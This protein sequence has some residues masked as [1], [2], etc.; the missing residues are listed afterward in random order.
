MNQGSS[1]QCLKKKTYQTN[2]DDINIYN[3][4]P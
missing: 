3:I 4:W 1:E 2:N